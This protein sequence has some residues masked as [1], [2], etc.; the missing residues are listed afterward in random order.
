MGCF[1]YGINRNLK[2]ALYLPWLKENKRNKRGLLGC[3]MGG[4]KHDLLSVNGFDEDYQLPAVGED[5][6]LEWRL[7]ACGINIK[8][9]FYQCLTYHLYHKSIHDGN[10]IEQIN[11]RAKMIEKQKAGHYFC[12]NGIK[13]IAFGN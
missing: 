5:S 1:L 7:R 3:N 6:D 2:R 13:K 11:N 12:L 9:V 4:F 8:T 10:S